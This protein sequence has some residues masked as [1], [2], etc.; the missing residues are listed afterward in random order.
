MSNNF[1]GNAELVIL[2]LF[3]RFKNAHAKK[4]HV[5][6]IYTFHFKFNILI[7]DM[8]VYNNVD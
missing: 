2:I 6:D 4:T 1:P 7:C 3:L 8:I 5:Y